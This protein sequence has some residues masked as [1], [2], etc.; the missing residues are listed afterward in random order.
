MNRVAGAADTLVIVCTKPGIAAV[1]APAS[2]MATPP[3]A[4]SDRWPA[5]LH[6]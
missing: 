5:P 6:R 1:A 2:L 4:P 3:T